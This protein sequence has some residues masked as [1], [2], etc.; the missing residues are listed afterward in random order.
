MIRT[1]LILVLVLGFSPHARGQSLSTGAIR[2]TVSDPSGAVV[3][4]ADITLTQ[5]PVGVARK[6]IYDEHVYLM[7]TIDFVYPPYGTIF[8]RTCSRFLHDNDF[9]PERISE[10]AELL[11]SLREQWEKEGSQFLSIAFKELQRPFPY[12]EMQVYLTVCD[13]NTMSMP[14]MV[15]VR[16][17]MAMAKDRLPLSFFPL[18]LFHELMHTYI[19]PAMATSALRKKYANEPPV[20]VNHLHVMALE[21]FALLRLGREEQLRYLGAQYERD[22]DYKRAWN[23]V[24]HVE[25]HE[26]FINELKRG[27]QE[28]PPKN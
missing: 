17:Y 11:P 3:A 4:N 20:I 19:S 22:P 26:V 12:K 7:P 1:T 28:N 6:N 27:M 24:V 15:N 25:G 16:P 9:K 23:I 8:D 21:R 13:V 18:E 2:G 10:A 14:L 5:E